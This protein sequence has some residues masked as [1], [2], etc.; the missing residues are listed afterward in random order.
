MLLMKRPIWRRSVPRPANLAS[1]PCCLLP[2]ASVFPF[3]LSPKPC[4]PHL[5]SCSLCSTLLR[6]CC[7]CQRQAGPPSPPGTALLPGL[8][9][10]RLESGAH[11]HHLPRL[12]CPHPPLLPRRRRCP[13]RWPPPCR[14][15]L[16]WE[17][18]DLPHNS[19]RRRR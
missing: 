6:C 16:C 14:I 2:D 15:P 8:Q 7:C 17:P 4:W 3:Q 1:C 9:G 19:R 11:D 10:P 13:L 18:S 12:H 5:P